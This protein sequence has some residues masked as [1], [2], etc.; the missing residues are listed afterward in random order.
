MQTKQL[1]VAIIQRGCPHYRIPLFKKISENDNIFLTVIVN[2]PQMQERS[3]AD[4]GFKLVY[5]PA[6]PL[7]FGY[8]NKT[9][10]IPIC[11]RIIS[12]LRKAKYD[13]VVTEG[14]T[15][16]I[17]NMLIY[18]TVRWMNGRYIW[19]GAGRR[20]FAPKNLLRRLADPFVHYIIRHA[21]A[22]IAYGT[23]ARDYMISVGASPE[24]VSI[25]Q[26][27]MDTNVIIYQHQDYSAQIKTIR[28]QLNLKTEQVILY[29][30]VIEKRKK[31]ENL[32]LAYDHLCKQQEELATLLIVGGGSHLR[33]LQN[34]TKRKFPDYNIHFLGKVIDGVD[35]YFAMCDVF[36]L[37]SE[38]GLALNQAMAFGKP[39]IATSADGTEI[40]LIQSGKNG[41]IVL[42]DDVS[43][44]ANTILNVLQSPQKQRFGNKSKDLM[45][46]T[47]TLENMVRG[48]ITAVENSWPR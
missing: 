28:Q 13:I 2:D 6:L 22:C 10:Q 23:V 48:F 45:Q 36:V 25:A 47:F 31:V 30:G 21:D 35:P 26:N 12:H 9:Y 20:R 4:L 44:L 33:T 16:I 34:W 24:K 42:E 15:N 8:G 39:V 18:P 41:Y 40:D 27:T 19:W 43:A 3:E 5:I 17:N 29:V 11:P 1:K 7:Q 14:V 46:H 32:I 38:G 37:P